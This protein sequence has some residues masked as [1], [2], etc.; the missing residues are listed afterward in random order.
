MNKIIKNVTVLYTDNNNEHFDAIRIAENG[1]YIG[2]IFDK[3]FEPFGFIP[4]HSIKQI[5]NGNGRKKY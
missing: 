5:N 1:V 4:N 3:K 2:R